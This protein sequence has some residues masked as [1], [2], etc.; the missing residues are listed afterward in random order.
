MELG[1][2]T[3]SRDFDDQRKSVL[4]NISVMPDTSMEQDLRKEL[5]T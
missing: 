3:Q 5:L 2:V 1:Q 4:P